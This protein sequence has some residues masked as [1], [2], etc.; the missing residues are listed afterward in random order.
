MFVLLNHSV[1]QKLGEASWGSRSSPCPGSESRILIPAP[2]W[3]SHEHESLISLS[4]KWR[5]NPCSPYSQGCWTKRIICMQHF[6]NGSVLHKYKTL[7]IQAHHVFL[8]RSGNVCRLVEKIF[9]HWL[10]CRD[11]TFQEL[12]HEGEVWGSGNGPK[13]GR[14]CICVIDLKCLPGTNS[15]PWFWP[16]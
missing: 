2:S 1:K 12:P 7:I 10:C 5:Q 8:W 15:S 13:G 9:N 6:E 4:S 11:C 14:K 16:L 3:A